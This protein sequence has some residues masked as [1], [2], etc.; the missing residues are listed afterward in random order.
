[1]RIPAGCALFSGSRAGEGAE[2]DGGV[3][4]ADPLK[5]PYVC[6]S[7]TLD[8]E[9]CGCGRGATAPARSSCPAPAAL[10]AS[11]SGIDE[12][13]KTVDFPSGV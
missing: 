7:S 2:Y 13:Y 12:S 8:G 9:V 5:Y 11:S 4:S 1:M 10:S 3:S 6:R